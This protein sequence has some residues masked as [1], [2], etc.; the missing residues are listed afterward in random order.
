MEMPRGL[1]TSG[2]HRC[3]TPADQSP[4]RTLDDRAEWLLWEDALF[5]PLGRSQHI[6]DSC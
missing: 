6:C 4:A 3:E 1:D 2:A 5:L